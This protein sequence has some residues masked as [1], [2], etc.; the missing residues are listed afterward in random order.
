VIGRPDCNSLTER[1]RSAFP[2][3]FGWRS[4][5]ARDATYA[6]ALS[7][8]IASGDNP[9]TPRY[10]VVVLAGLSAEATTRTPKALFHR[11]A[12]GANAIVLPHGQ[13]AKPLVMTEPAAR[14]AAK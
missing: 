5:V 4:F 3:T 11:H 7:A 1:F 9:A 8:V 13:K 14:R 2:V 6:H 10:S 12:A